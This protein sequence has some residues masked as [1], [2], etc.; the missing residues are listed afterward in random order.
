MGS[1][2]AIGGYKTD[3]SEEGCFDTP[4]KIDQRVVKL[5]GKKHPKVLFIPTASSDGPSYT[6]SFIKVYGEKLGC[7][8]EVL[9]LIVEKPSHAEITA[10]IAWADLIYV[11]GGNTLMMMNKW[12]RLGVDQL[13]RKAHK[14]GAVLAGVSAGAICWYEWGVSDSRQFKNPKS[15]EYIRVRGLGFL[16]GLCCPHYDAVPSKTNWRLKGLKKILKTWKGEWV[17][18]ETGE[19]VFISLPPPPKKSE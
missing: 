18:I 16:K 12:R 2:V 10:K 14:R 15:H 7:P 6:K 17:G 3:W 9:R 8:V 19:A 1:I 11:G 13:L 5:T 4:F